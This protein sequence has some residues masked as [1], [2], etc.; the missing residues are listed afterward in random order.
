MT[1]RKFENGTT[2]CPCCGSIVSEQ[3]LRERERQRRRAVMD[4]HFREQ[5]AESQQEESSK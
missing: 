3:T 1:E 4:K 2:V 5:F